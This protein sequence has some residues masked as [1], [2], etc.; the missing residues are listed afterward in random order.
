[1]KLQVV[2][3]IAIV[4]AYVS[5]SEFKCNPE[6][7]Y[8]VNDCNNCKCFKNDLMCTRLACPRP[9]SKR[10]AQCEVGTTFKRDCNDC[11]IPLRS[12]YMNFLSVAIFLGKQFVI[13]PR[14]ELKYAWECEKHKVTCML[15]SVWDVFG[16]CHYGGLKRTEFKYLKQMIIGG[17]VLSQSKMDLVKKVFPGVTLCN[18]YGQTETGVVFLVSPSGSKKFDRLGKRSECLGK[19]LPGITYKI[20]KT[21]SPLDQIKKGSLE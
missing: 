12:A 21:N 9:E 17:S 10:L 15:I 13:Y 19:G 7:Q 20:Y 5:A 8:R 11:C 16:M 14:F 1:M 3:L 4:V 2:V 6:E 18:T